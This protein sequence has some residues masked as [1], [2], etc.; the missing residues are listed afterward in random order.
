[1]DELVL[2]DYYDP[3]SSYDSVVG[4]WVMGTN[5]VPLP[6]SIWLM[7]SALPGMML[8]TRRKH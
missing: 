1:M 7:L 6:A 5:P 3:L 8:L 2:L 4:A